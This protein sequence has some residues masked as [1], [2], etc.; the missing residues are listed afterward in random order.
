MSNYWQDRQA[1]SQA[2]LTTKNIEDIQKQ[3]NKYYNTVSNSVIKSFEE[4]FFELVYQMENDMDLTPAKLYKLDTYWK[5]QGQVK[6]ELQKLGDREIELLSKR[7]VEQYIDIYKSMALPS[8]SFFVS[9]DTGTVEQM[10]KSIWCAD[11]KTWDA[12]IWKD[13]DKLQEALNQGLIDVVV[14]GKDTKELKKQLRSHLKEQFQHSYSRVN[15]LVN[16]EM[17]HIQTQA[18]NDRYKDAGVEWVEIWASKDERRCDVCGELHQKKIRVGEHI[19]IP[20]HP[21]CRCCLLP[22]I[23]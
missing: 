9:L 3:L 12:R 17:A 4:T 10:I 22:V 21:N 2:K 15:T 14:A 13:I 6:R 1:A 8:N 19:P 16:T 23:D 18:A 7:F 20:A 11:G 5:M